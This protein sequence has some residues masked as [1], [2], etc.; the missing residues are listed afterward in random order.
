MMISPY[1]PT[2]ISEDEV[3]LSKWIL[4]KYQLFYPPCDN[5]SPDV[6][7][8]LTL[9]YNCFPSRFQKELIFNMAKPNFYDRKLGARPDA[10]TN[11]ITCTQGFFFLST[12]AILT[13][14]QVVRSGG[15]H[16]IYH[17]PPSYILQSFKKSHPIISLELTGWL[18]NNTVYGVHLITYGLRLCWYSFPRG[19]REN[20][21]P[22][23]SESFVTVLFFTLLSFTLL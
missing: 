8:T 17:I 11:R 14:A 6:S 5:S 23:G 7:Q 9:S 10:Q 18:K 22:L 4:P 1:L 20:A 16:I 21:F 19:V 13:D 2:T 3:R 12:L 15:T